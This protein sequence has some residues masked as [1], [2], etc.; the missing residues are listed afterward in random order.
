MKQVRSQGV[1]SEQGTTKD[2]FYIVSV[3]HT[4]RRHRYITFWRSDDRGYAYPL[5][6]SGKYTRGQVEASL[7][8]YNSGCSTIAVRCEAV[9]SLAVDPVPGE[10]DN[11][12][13]PVVHNNGENWKALLANVIS[14]PKY[15]PAPEYRGA[16]RKAA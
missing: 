13:G 8:Y 6:W 16:R 1:M 11:D 4:Q 14:E 2:L 10:I 9:D 7:G 15:K 3:K 5:S 12:A